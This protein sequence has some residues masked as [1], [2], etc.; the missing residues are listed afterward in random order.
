M[1]LQV[2]IRQ[3]MPYSQVVR[4][5]LLLIGKNAGVP[6][7][8]CSGPPAGGL[9]WDHT[10]PDSRPLAL[11]FYEAIRK[12]DARPGSDFFRTVPAIRTPEG[13]PD[14]MAELVYMVNC[15]QE[16]N[17]EPALLD[18]FG[19]F[20]YSHSYQA[21]FACIEK[22]LVQEKIDDL[23]RDWGLKAVRQKS[24]FF[25]SHDIDTLYGSL[26]Q[27]G[28]WALRHLQPGALLRLMLWEVLRRPHWRNI[29]QILKIS[30]EYDIRTTF[31]W[32]VNRGMGK[33][34]VQ[35]ADY[36]IDRE[37]ELLRRV[38]EAGSVNG[39]HK[40]SSDMTL[41]QEMEKGRIDHPFNRYH[42]LRFLPHR[43]W[44]EVAAS[45]IRFD[46]SLGF[47][48]HYGFRNSY[49][50]A[51]QPFDLKAEKPYPFVEAPLHFMDGTFH[52]YMNI[53]AEETAD[54]IIE[55]YEKNSWNCDFSLLWHNTYFSNY[56]YRPYLQ[57]YKKLVAYFRDSGIACVTPEEIIQDNLLSW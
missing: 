52:R 7:E 54:I 46:C 53:P 18:R 5:G 48:E 45:G 30:S 13:Q 21:R 42:F 1:S 50:R 40:S 14:S 37:N 9:I 4:Y 20:G 35:N 55:F 27:D 33:D 49:G 17:P 38:R 43:D 11:P 57:E 56:K 44:P 24:R 47:A 26:F 31:F 34:S 39:L 8:F 2:Y 25:I 22:N 16:L 29:D 12:E 6:V 19:R 32:L 23:C 41:R 36:D 10:H 51:F 28:F 3:G 15:L